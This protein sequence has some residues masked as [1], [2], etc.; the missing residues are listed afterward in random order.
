M[1][2]AILLATMIFTVCHIIGAKPYSESV[3]LK[4]FFLCA[5]SLQLKNIETLP[6]NK[7]CDAV[8]LTLKCLTKEKGNLRQRM[9]PLLHRLKSLCSS[10]TPEEERAAISAPE[11]GSGETNL[12]VWNQISPLCFLMTVMM[13]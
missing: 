2:A 11:E 10:P 8:E 5:D 3:C 1:P 7:F 4:V 6:D 13:I 12:A 9:V